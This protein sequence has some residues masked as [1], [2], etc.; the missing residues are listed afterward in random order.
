MCLFSYILLFHSFAA[1]DLAGIMVWSL[2]LDDFN[3][4]QCGQGKNPLINTVKDYLENVTKSQMRKI[5]TL[6]KPSKRSRKR[7]SHKTYERRRSIKQQNRR[8]YNRNRRT[9]RRRR[10][11]RAIGSWSGRKALGLDQWCSKSCNIGNCPSLLCIC[12]L[13]V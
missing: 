9:Y 4:S 7:V 10:K 1:K 6:N 5:P 13:L 2:A 8:T 3:G 11:C 12:E